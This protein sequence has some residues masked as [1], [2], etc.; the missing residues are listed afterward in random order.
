MLPYEVAD[1]RSGFQLRRAAANMLNNE[2]QKADERRYFM[3]GV[4]QRLKSLNANKKLEWYFMIHMALV[5]NEIFCT[6]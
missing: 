1:E 6:N 3:L 2:F 4:G 5:L